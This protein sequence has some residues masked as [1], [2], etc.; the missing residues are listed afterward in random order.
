MWEWI[1]AVGPPGLHCSTAASEIRPSGNSLE[2]FNATQYILNIGSLPVAS[3]WEM[4]IRSARSVCA[5]EFVS[6]S[7]PYDLGQR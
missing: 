4:I 5:L 1:K 7:E 3:V 6:I 2:F